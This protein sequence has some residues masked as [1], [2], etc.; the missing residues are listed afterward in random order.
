ME[1]IPANMETPVV[2]ATPTP[3]FN[4]VVR[5][6]AFTF[7]AKAAFNVY[8]DDELKYPFVPFD[9]TPFRYDYGDYVAEWIYG[10][11][12]RS[13]CYTDPKTSAVKAISLVLPDSYAESEY[14]TLYKK[15]FMKYFH[16]LLNL[17]HVG[18]NQQ[19]I[20]KELKFDGFING[21]PT[22]YDGEGVRVEA[23]WDDEYLLVLLYPQDTDLDV[24]SLPMKIEH[25]DDYLKYED[26][27]RALTDMVY[28]ADYQGVLDSINE[29]INRER[30]PAGD[31]AFAI[32]ALAQTG[33]EL[34]ASCKIVWDEAE[35][36]P[37]IYYKGVDKITADVNIVPYLEVLWYE[38][39]ISLMP[40]L[41][42]ELI[43]VAFGFKAPNRVLFED[44]FV[45]FNDGEEPYEDYF[46]DDEIVR[47]SVDGGVIG[48]AESV[49]WSEEDTVG[50]GIFTRFAVCERGRQE[51]GS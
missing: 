50:K 8:G 35:Q 34:M 45:E 44:V 42:N 28:T 19:T 10:L 6:G 20:F 31:S 47:D 26:R 46:S 9:K 12:L 33:A 29:Y 51:T 37:Y 49:F 5:D 11:P 4:P 39:G 1:Q 22:Y 21:I 14:G 48:Y 16:N 27:R 7:D 36:T 38:P 30:P 24:A 25:P 13:I 18:G 23:R 17:C 40:Y 2:S 32:R 41:N 3:R 43:N 15:Y